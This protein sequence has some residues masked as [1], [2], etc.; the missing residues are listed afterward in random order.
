MRRA[1]KSTAFRWNAAGSAPSPRLLP[2][3]R[4]VAHRADGKPR[5]LALQPQPP[6]L[7]LGGDGALR[8][9]VIHYL[10]QRGADGAIDRQL[11]RAV[12]GFNVAA[13][14]QPP[15][16][17]VK[18]AEHPAFQG[19]KLEFILRAFAGLVRRAALARLDFGPRRLAVLRQRRRPGHAQK[20][21]FTR[22]FRFLGP[23]RHQKTMERHAPGP[24]LP[25]VAG[26]DECLLV[27][28]LVNPADKLALLNQP[29][30][31]S[32]LRRL[33]CVLHEMIGC[34]KMI[35][36]ATRGFP[37]ARRV[38][39]NFVGDENSPTPFCHLP[40]SDFWLPP[41]ASRCRAKLKRGR[42]HARRL[43]AV[44]AVHRAACRAER[45]PA[46]V[47]RCDP[48]RKIR[49]APIRLPP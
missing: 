32:G 19:A 9:D 30:H 11:R 27:V 13:E 7:L 12:V 2:V 29:V 33:F 5:Q 35:L 20:Q 42:R 34:R 16:P 10:F 36:T 39:V 40:N 44:G 6:R 43:L 28:H 26:Q 15:V 31:R 4:G 48:R 37:T 25:F 8:A 45:R 18:R 22:R 3:R 21:D 38:K 47:A 14:A 17:L 1:R 41:S 49:A 24:Q 23:R 46:P